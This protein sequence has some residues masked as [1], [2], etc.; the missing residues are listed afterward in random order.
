MEG[1]GCQMDD[2]LVFGNDIVQ[3]DIRLLEVMKR[4]ESAGVTLNAGRYKFRMEEVN[5]LG[6]LI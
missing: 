1:V 4:L 2:I 3:H 6:H 5:F